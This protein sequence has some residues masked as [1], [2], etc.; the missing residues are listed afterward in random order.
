MSI[1]NIG[2]KYNNNN[3][4][5]HKL[6]ASMNSKPTGILGSSIN[7]RPLPDASGTN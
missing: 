5:D 7:R 3:M 6:T 2:S 4:P 1:N